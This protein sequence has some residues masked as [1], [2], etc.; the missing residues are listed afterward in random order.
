MTKVFIRKFYKL[1]RIATVK[2]NARVCHL[3]KLD[4]KHVGG[5]RELFNSEIDRQWMAQPLPLTHR[6]LCLAQIFGRDAIERDQDVVIGTEFDVIAR[7]RG[8]VEHDR[9]EVCSMRRAQILDESVQ[10][11]LYYSL[12]H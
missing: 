2:N 3:V 6:C 5:I 4:R 11:F 12:S 9:S 1:E 10:C 8:A 7:C